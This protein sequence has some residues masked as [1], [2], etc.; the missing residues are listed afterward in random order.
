[1]VSLG[2]IIFA[3]CF[4]SAAVAFYASKRRKTADADLGAVSDHWISEYRLGRGDGDGG[5]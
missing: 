2:W 1:M 4:I 5:R 3:L